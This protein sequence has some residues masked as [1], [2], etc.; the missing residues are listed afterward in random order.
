MRT[1][2]TLDADV[3]VLVEKAMKNRGLTFKE[4]VNDALRRS[5]G[6]S[7][8]RNRFETPTFALGTPGASLDKA[9]QITAELDDEEVARKFDLRK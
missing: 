5:L 7:A 8:E 3:S 1:T 4:A 9:L 6:S 2:I